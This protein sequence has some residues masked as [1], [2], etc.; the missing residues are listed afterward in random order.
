[1][2]LDNVALALIGGIAVTII[3]FVFGV[4]IGAYFFKDKH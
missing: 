2:L 4:T 1:M 3:G